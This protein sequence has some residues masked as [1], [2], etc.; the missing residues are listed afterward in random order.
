[1]HDMQFTG[2]T[3][4]K[5]CLVFEEGVCPVSQTLSGKCPQQSGVKHWIQIR[6]NCVERKADERRFY[7]VITSH[8]T[9]TNKVKF[10]RGSGPRTLDTK[11][12]L[13]RLWHQHGTPHLLELKEL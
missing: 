1:M 12:G 11:F 4:V 10:H 2:E 6:G 13:C 9:D 5:Q 7:I 8:V 3:H